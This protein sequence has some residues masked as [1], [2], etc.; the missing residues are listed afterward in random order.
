[1]V[2]LS[3]MAIILLPISFVVFAAAV[4][5]GRRDGTLMQY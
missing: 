5:T 3:V 1:M 4:G 2:T